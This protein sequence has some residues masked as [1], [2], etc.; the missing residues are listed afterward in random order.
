LRHA[1]PAGKGGVGTAEDDDVFAV[2]LNDHADEAALA[3][4]IV[5]VCLEIAEVF[6][7]LAE[8]GNLRT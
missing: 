6:A 4:V 8:Y 2:D 3:V 5:A 1:R 7:V